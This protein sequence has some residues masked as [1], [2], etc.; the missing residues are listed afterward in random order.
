MFESRRR[1]DVDMIFLQ[2]TP[3]LGRLLTP[4]LRF[5]KA[6]DIPTYATSDIYDTARTTRDS[7]LNGVIFPDLPILVD[8]DPAAADLAAA[9]REYWPQQ[10]RQWIRLYSFGFD[11]Y[12]LVKPIFS[13]APGDWPVTGTTGQLRLA[14]DGRVHRALPFAQF[15]NGTPAAVA[16]LPPV[17]PGGFE[18]SS[19]TPVDRRLPAR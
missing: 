17:V 7:D 18:L 11:A 16:P 1:D 13:P 9:F 2:A 8:P 19:V 4:Q 12:Q 14:S 5:H 10:S 3:G 6:G 15:R